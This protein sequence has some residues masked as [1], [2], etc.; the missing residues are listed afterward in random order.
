MSGGDRAVTSGESLKKHA[1]GKAVEF[2]DLEDWLHL[3][4]RL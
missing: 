4:F 3:F 1:S 2:P